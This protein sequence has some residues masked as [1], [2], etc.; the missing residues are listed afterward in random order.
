MLHY[1]DGVRG[2]FSVLF[3]FDPSIIN[4][5]KL[6]CLKTVHILISWETVSVCQKLWMAWPSLLF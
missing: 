1:Y 6:N 5:D 2:E 4:Y 3:T